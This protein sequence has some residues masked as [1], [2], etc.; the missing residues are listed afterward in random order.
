ME[1]F[2]KRTGLALSALISCCALAGTV[3]TKDGQGFTGL[4]QFADAEHLSVGPAKGPRKLIALADVLTATFD[5]PLNPDQLAHGAPMAG[6][7]RGLLASYHDRPN[8]KGRVIYRLDETINHQWR[9]KQPVFDLPRDYFSVRWSGE[10]EAPV[11]GEYTFTLL[12][13]DG[14]KLKVGTLEVGRME[15][16]AGFRERG[17]VTLQGGKRV[18]FVFEFFDNYGE[19]SARIHW[20]GPGFQAGPIPSRQL[21]PA[22]PVTRA[23]RGIAGQHGLLG[24]YYQNR[25][26]YGDA[27]LAIDPKL[28]FAAVKPPKEF[29]DKNY[30]VRWTGQLEAT[31]T[32]EYTFKVETDEGVRL[33]I[34]GRLVVNQ[35]SNRALQTF[36]GT[37]PLERGKRYNV[38]LESVHRTGGGRLKASWVSRSMQ[39][40]VL[41]G[42]TTS[43]FFQP[44]V[45]EKL[46]GGEVE[47]SQ[48]LG[49]FSWGGSRLA[50][51]VTTADD[52]AVRFEEGSS[53]TRIS[54][55]NVAR[56]VFK[57]VPE[58]YRARLA[59]QRKGVL[60]TN[61]DFIEGELQELKTDWLTI[62]S[63][64]F[65]IKV[66]GR[67]EVIALVLGKIAD[68]PVRSAK[69]EVRL[70]NGSL[71]FARRF[72]LGKGS[73]EV[74]DPTVG[75]VNIPLAELEEVR[76]V[77]R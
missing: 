62:N 73:V 18:P 36:T 12:A 63:V 4:V 42:T 34:G 39:E 43:P 16:L 50:V 52:S 8:F 25:F 15:A 26:F 3:T 72:K 59:A 20:Q 35:L 54:T 47:E 51:A 17:K 75:K 58:R 55:V 64:L 13:N 21:Y 19:A 40:V 69:Y 56:I 45:P 30:S 70:E 77:K 28:D 66:Y 7:G 65:G 27:V 1:T 68:K 31:H 6:K 23:P 46:E 61:G 14:G 49:V 11:T 37:A 32:E 5:P 10:L 38:R 41:G 57:P 76:A 60:L 24:S 74:D 2:L 48:M 22:V 9:S 67:G 29:A 53:P 71:L 44:P 33:W